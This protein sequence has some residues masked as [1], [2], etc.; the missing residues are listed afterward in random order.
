MSMAYTQAMSGMNEEPAAVRRRRRQAQNPGMYSSFAGTGTQAAQAGP[1]P[2]QPTGNTPR[3]ALS[4]SPATPANRQQQPQRGPTPLTYTNFAQG[5][6]PVELPVRLPRSTL[7][8]DGGAA[9]RGVQSFRYRGQVLTEQ[10]LRT[11]YPEI[12]QSFLREEAAAGNSPDNPG[13][14]S[15]NPTPTSAPPAPYTFEYYAGQAEQEHEEANAA[16]LRRYNQAL[17]NL[18]RQENRMQGYYDQVDQ[19]E[20]NNLGIMRGQMA[21]ASNELTGR[22]SDINAGYEAVQRDYDT[23]R[24]EIE[25]VGA[26]ALAD[27]ERRGA[28]RTAQTEQDSLD[29]G[30]YNTSYLD[31]ARRREGETTGREK[32]GIY[33]SMAAA[34]SDIA[35]NRAG[36]RERGI[37]ASAD[38]RGDI[39]Q[40]WNQRAAAED[41]AGQRRVKNINDRMLMDIGLNEQE[42]GILLSRI[43]EG[44]DLGQLAAAAAGIAYQREQANRGSGNGLLS[45]ILPI[46]GGIFGSVVPGVGT[47][48]GI[49]AGTALGAATDGR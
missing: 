8:G 32:A 21:N 5:S 2:I 29:R 46:V 3:A 10:Q 23:A 25:G 40:N 38:A 31:S 45:S 44:A 43:D 34:R 19:A 22:L 47:A 26:Q 17:G 37:G 18:H 15:N 20:A 39:A 41:V 48:T 42:R 11:R 7:Q 4:A 27:A 35:Q 36:A 6:A 16:N 49:A 30:L 12:Y 1:Q 13:G 28:S 24:S 33:E 14:G 9:N